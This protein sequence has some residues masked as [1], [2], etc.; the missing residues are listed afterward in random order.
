[1]LLAVDAQCHCIM[2]E[3]ITVE[4]KKIEYILVYHTTF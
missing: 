3:P 1:M 2:D 4:P